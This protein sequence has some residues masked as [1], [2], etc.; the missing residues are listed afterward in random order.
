MDW[1]AL[2]LQ[3]MFGLTVSPFELMLRGSLMYL[4]IFSTVRV[5]LRREAAAISLPDLIMV[6]LIADAAQ[7][8][9]TSGYQSVTDGAILVG[10]IILWNFTL[11]RLSFHFPWIERFIHP[12]PLLIIRNGRMLW[13][14]MRTESISKEELMSQLRE[15]GIEDIADV[16][17]AHVEGDG[18]ISIIKQQ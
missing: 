6:T 3:K 10:T 1:F 17:S 18:R 5:L 15:A 12:P 8:A 4:G 13:R 2:D 14:N 7:N 11:D 16:K 9:M